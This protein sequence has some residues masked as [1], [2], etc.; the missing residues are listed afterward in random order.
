MLSPSNLLNYVAGSEAEEKKSIPARD[1][2]AM[3]LN[4]ETEV[5]VKYVVSK[6]VEPLSEFLTKVIIMKEICHLH[7]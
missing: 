7:P 6:C 4:E 3:V 5:L 1:W 2:I